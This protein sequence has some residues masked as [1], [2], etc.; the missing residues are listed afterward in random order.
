LTTF[1]D[2]DREAAPHTDG[3]PHRLS[4]MAKLLFIQL[5]CRLASQLPVDMDNAYTLLAHT[6]E[7]SSYQ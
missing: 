7:G 3:E 5:P 1:F 4:L 6:K 2:T